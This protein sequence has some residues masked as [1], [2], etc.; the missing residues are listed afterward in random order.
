MLS[1]RSSI[2][3][4]LSRSVLSFRISVPRKSVGRGSW[5][6]RRPLFLSPWRS[7][8]LARG[9]PRAGL[10]RRLD[11]AL[12]RSARDLPRVLGVARLETDVV[13]AQL[14]LHRGFLAIGLERAG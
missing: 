13:A 7:A 1:A 4:W 8:A 9:G 11:R 3:C 5:V 10:A 12:D 6:V 2:H 14:P